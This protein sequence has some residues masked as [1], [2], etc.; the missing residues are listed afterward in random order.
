MAV[1]VL[2]PAGFIVGSWLDSRGGDERQSRGILAK[3]APKGVIDEATG[4]YRGVK[5]GDTVADVRRILGTPIESGGLYSPQVAWNTAWNGFNP[6]ACRSWKRKSG[7]FH[8]MVYREI[9]FNIVG[10]RVCSYEVAGS[11]WSTTGG[12]RA[13]DGIE[14]IRARFGEGACQESNFTED[15]FWKQWTCIGRTDSGI[16]MEFA[17]DPVSSVGIVVDRPLNAN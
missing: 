7:D 6:P 2:V 14:R 16:R 8:A 17:G 9:V 5:R 13:G 10:G 3:P 4:T 1:I 15:P 11:G 12:T